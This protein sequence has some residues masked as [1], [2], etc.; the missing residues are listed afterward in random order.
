VTDE[1]PAGGSAWELSEAIKEMGLAVAS[2]DPDRIATAMRRHAEAMTNAIVA[3]YM[4]TFEKV[5]KASVS[6]AIQEMSAA[7]DSLRGHQDQ[8]FS[9]LIRISEAE[10]QTNAAW[11]DT[12]SKEIDALVA[13]Q[14]DLKEDH[15]ALR[16]A[17]A[18]ALARIEAIEA[19]LAARP[20]ERAAEHQAIIEEI[21][22]PVHAVMDRL[23]RKR[24]ELDA[25]H[26]WQARIEARLAELER[27]RRAN[28]TERG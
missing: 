27:L 17:V 26:D 6:P 1:I 2:A 15:V 12:Y 21:A 14:A 13:G 23:D 11:R 24:Q 10:Y 9:Y 18:G 25:I 4:P 3:A 20:A 8:R 22:G 5:L 7:I 16:G 28:D 19:L